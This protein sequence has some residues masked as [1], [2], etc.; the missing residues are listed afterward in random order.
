M[1]AA[2]AVLEGDLK[3][4]ATAKRCLQ[5]FDGE[6]IGTRSARDRHEVDGDEIEI[7][8]R[9]GHSPPQPQGRQSDERRLERRHQGMASMP[10]A[11]FAS[12]VRQ[13]DLL[14]HKGQG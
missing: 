5:L 13:M 3:L 8:T 7:E 10:E 4:V 2:G 14:K 9:V 6:D 1:R 11:L 12:L